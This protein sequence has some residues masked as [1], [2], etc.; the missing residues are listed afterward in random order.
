M[1]KI[2]V[3]L[4]IDP[5]KK[6]FFEGKNLDVEE[7]PS[8]SQIVIFDRDNSRREKKGG[9]NDYLFWRYVDRPDLARQVKLLEA[10][11]KKIDRAIDTKHIRDDDKLQ[12]IHQL[13]QKEKPPVFLFEEP[14]KDI[15][16]LNLGYLKN[17]AEKLPSG[18]PRETLLAALYAV[19]TFIEEDK[20]PHW[21]INPDDPDWSWD[22][23]TSSFKEYSK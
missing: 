7:G 18:Y 1:E 10:V 15:L 5:E 17:S 23:F 13:I 14:D 19:M 3:M 8:T 9:F 22:K 6:E 12:L 4:S 11:F 2:M 21:S 20:L 16:M